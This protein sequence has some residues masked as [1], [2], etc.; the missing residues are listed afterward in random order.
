MR[1]GFT[2]LEL[3]VAITILTI[4]IG[5]IYAS[6]ATVTASVSSTRVDAEELRLRQFLARSLTQNLSTAYADLDHQRLEFGFRGVNGEDT[7]DSQDS[8]E[9]CSTSTLIGGMALPGALKVVRY[10]VI[11][12]EESESLFDDDE[13]VSEYALTAM[14]QAVETPLLVGG[15]VALDDAVGEIE[16]AESAMAEL[17]LDS[18]SWSVPIGSM[19]LEYFDG[20]EWVEEWDSTELGRLP[21]GVHVKINFAKTEAQLDAD[22]EDG[23]DP[24]EDPDFEM[25][26]PVPL[27]VGT[28]ED[29]QIIADVIRRGDDDDESSEQESKR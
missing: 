12:Q 9:F 19:E 24:D 28:I 10:E 4:V 25:F 26:I 8:L 14:L 5:I 16:D 7:E 23:L 22:E 20:T 18:P 15:D 2:L 3:L 17:G 13:N 29:G 6:F 11:P 21:W 27:G 1:K